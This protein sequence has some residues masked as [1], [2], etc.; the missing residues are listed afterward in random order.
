MQWGDVYVPVEAHCGHYINST[1]TML[2]FL[3]SHMLS[4]FSVRYNHMPCLLF[5]FFQL[6]F[7][8]LSCILDS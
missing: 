3:S 1:L 2:R 6:G 5:L 4:S 7:V 8:F